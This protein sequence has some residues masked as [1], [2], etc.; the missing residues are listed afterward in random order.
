MESA[1][2][3]RNTEIEEANSQ[4]SLSLEGIKL[5]KEA[6]IEAHRPQQRISKEEREARERLKILF[7][8][9]SLGFISCDKLI[10]E[11][12]KISLFC[13]VANLN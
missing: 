1:E 10:T 12:Y 6:T 11:L 7:S 3:K 5:Y 9:V 8:K 4:Y 2:K 13:F